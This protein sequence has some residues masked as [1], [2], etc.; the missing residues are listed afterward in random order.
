MR[1]PR[2]CCVWFYWVLEQLQ[3]SNP[4]LKSALRSALNIL[5]SLVMQRFGFQYEEPGAIQQETVCSASNCILSI[6]LTRN[7][8]HVISKNNIT[9]RRIFSIVIIFGS[10]SEIFWLLSR[11]MQVVKVLLNVSDII[12]VKPLSRT[13][14]SLYLPSNRFYYVEKRV[15][16]VW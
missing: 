10:S 15:E 7:F 13:Y 16:I 8:Q 9:L 1:R 2:F 14:T 12:H 5:S 6:T 11:K 4:K 3:C